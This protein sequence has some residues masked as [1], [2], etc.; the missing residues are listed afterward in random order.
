MRYD[1]KILKVLKDK[2]GF[3]YILTCVMILFVVMLIF[4]L[5]QYQY[6]YHTASEQRDSVQLEIDSYI[7][8]KA[9][10]C[11]DAL[12][13][14][15]SY[16]KYID[17]TG[18]VEG[19]YDLLGFSSNN[20]QEFKEISGTDIVYTMSRPEVYSLINGSFGVRVKYMLTIPFELFG[21]KVADIQVPVE[22]VSKFTEK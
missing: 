21:H 11:Y 8:K 14:G 20:T 4:A 13:Q 5:L 16:E 7:T 15:E 10:T 18:I 12:K 17:N 9:M 22:L 19:A 3:S 6:I 1:M 2:S